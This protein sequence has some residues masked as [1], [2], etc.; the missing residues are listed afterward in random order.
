MSGRD[1]DRGKRA[2]RRIRWSEIVGYS[3]I[4]L[5]IIIIAYLAAPE[6]QFSTSNVQT[7]APQVKRAAV[8]DQLSAI[9][10]SS[11]LIQSAYSM[12][13]SR[14]IS[15]DIFLPGDI[16]VDFYASLASRGYDLII[17]RVH[18]GLGNAQAPI[19]LFT[20]EPYDPNRYVLE[21]GDGLV[22]S[23]QADSGGPV[24]FA[25]TP[26][27]IREKM[28]GQF[29][30]TIIVL[31]GCYGLHGGDLAD[32]FVSKGARVVVGWSGLVDL[33][34]TDAALSAFM[35]DFIQQNMT[36]R[37]SVDATMTV[38]G[39]DPNSGSALS[40]Y[41]SDQGD[42]TLALYAA[43]HGILTAATSQELRSKPFDA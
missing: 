28:Q 24:V 43:Q 15:T 26:K 34:H 16:T 1:R 31:G 19:G 21:Q 22:G 5:L 2:K 38:V 36:I 41:P 12:L 3:A 29:Q 30:G 42:V 27:F 6:Y 37:N 14:G 23:A 8:I 32:A 40:Y 10:P 20:N 9:K 35:K 33:D 39:P 17:L 25:V 11:G 13:T 4:L 18:T 7:S